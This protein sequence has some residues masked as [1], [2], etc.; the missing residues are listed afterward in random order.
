MRFQRSVAGLTLSALF[1]AAPLLA[2]QKQVDPAKALEGFSIE[3]KR[4]SSGKVSEAVFYTPDTVLII[5]RK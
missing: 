5:K 1:I 2:Q 3:F 4:D